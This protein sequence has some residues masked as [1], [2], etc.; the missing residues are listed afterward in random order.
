ME[1]KLTAIMF[2]DIVGYSRIMS[3]NEERCL[4]LLT[5]HDNILLP[6][7]N[8]FHGK[9]LKRMGDA[10][11]VDFS[12]S[13]NSVECAI[14]LQTKLKEFNTNKSFDDK[15]LLRIGIHIGD[16]DVAGVGFVATG[17]VKVLVCFVG[18]ACSS[19]TSSLA[20]LPV[21]GL[22]GSIFASFGS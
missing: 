1:R 4:E 16:G 12:S 5:E 11:F 22:L 21:K 6:V 2:T 18:V 17:G 19:A 3:N 15:L 9:I 10:L 8:Q 7:I 14:A 20:L 13:V